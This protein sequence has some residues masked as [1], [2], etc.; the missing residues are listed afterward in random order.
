M[1]TYR[2]II[3]LLCKIFKRREIE[4]LDY[5]TYFLLKYD[6]ILQNKNG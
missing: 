5:C 3:I 6:D 4:I 1:I 2:I